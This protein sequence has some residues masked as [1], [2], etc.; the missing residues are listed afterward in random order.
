MSLNCVYNR[1]IS[2]CIETTKIVIRNE[3]KG[4]SEYAQLVNRDNVECGGLL[5]ESNIESLAEGNKIERSGKC[6]RSRTASIASN[7]VSDLLS[8][9]SNEFLLRHLLSNLETV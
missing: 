8:N 5:L 6:K 9:Y 2:I 4:L 7:A 1:T 3:W